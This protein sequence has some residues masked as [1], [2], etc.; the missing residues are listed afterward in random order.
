MTVEKVDVE[1]FPRCYVNLE[2]VMAF[3]DTLEDENRVPVQYKELFAQLAVRMCDLQFKKEGKVILF[4]RVVCGAGKD[5]DEVMDALGWTSK[6][7]FQRGLRDLCECNVMHKLKND[8]YQVNPAYVNF[9]YK[10]K[11]KEANL[12]K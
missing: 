2:D 1:V 4:P 7:K 3:L 11:V 5:A 8:C 12:E 6:E 10:R 9:E